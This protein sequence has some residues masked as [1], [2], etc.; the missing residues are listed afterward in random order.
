MNEMSNM[1]RVGA[2]IE[3]VEGIGA[4]S[5]IGYSFIYPGPGYG[6]SCFPKDIKALINTASNNAY[7]SDTEGSRRDQ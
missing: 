6:G 3:S 5:R 7:D 4:D 2:D 1:E